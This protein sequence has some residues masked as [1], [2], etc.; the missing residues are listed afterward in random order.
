MSPLSNRLRAAWQAFQSAEQDPHPQPTPE[1]V[2]PL[3][4]EALSRWRETRVNWNYPW[5][6]HLTPLHL[7]VQG[8]APDDDPVA[9]PLRVQTANLSILFL[10][11]RSWLSGDKPIA[12]FAGKGREVRLALPKAGDAAVVVSGSAAKALVALVEWAYTKDRGG[13]RLSVVQ[14]TIARELES[15]DDP[16]VAYRSLVAGVETM[17]VAVKAEWKFV[18]DGEVKEFL[19]QV[20]ALE[21]EVSS[22]VQAFSDRT[23]AMIK[24]LSETALAAVAAL[25]GSFIAALVKGGAGRFILW[26][27]VATYLV[28]LVLFPLGYNMS[29]QFQSYRALVKQFAARRK[30]FEQRLSADKVKEIVGERVAQSQRSYW[31]WFLLTLLA[32]VFVIEAMIVVVLWLGP[33]LQAG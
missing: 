30:R 32:Y 29:Q 13:E 16:Q 33:R 25:I 21:D 23:S 24:S 14:N 15:S 10:A 18:L 19:Q 4:P 22:T 3:T 9:R 12:A 8:D 5:T 6:D 1:P 17:F 26:I 27:G 31:T 7:S 2:P 11:D 20:Q 28:Y